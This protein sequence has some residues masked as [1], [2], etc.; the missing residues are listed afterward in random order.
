M[1]GC[2][3]VLKEKWPQMQVVAIEPTSSPVLSGGRAGPHMLQGIGAGFIPGTCHVNLLDRIIKVS[4]A[5]AFEY[6]QRAAREEGIFGGISTGACLAAVEIILRTARPGSTVLTFN[7]DTGDRY[8]SVTDLFT[9]D[10]DAITYV[11]RE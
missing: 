5:E 11:P 6:T 1:T 9:A 8:L 4:E 3:M 7:Y 2:A 10:E